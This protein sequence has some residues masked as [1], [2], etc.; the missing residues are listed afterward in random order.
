MWQYRGSDVDCI[1]ITLRLA[2]ICA[3]HITM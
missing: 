2:Q 3:R 1:N